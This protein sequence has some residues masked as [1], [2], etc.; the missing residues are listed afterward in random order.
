MYMYRSDTSDSL[1]PAQMPQMARP[2]WCV[3][4]WHIEQIPLPC[5]CPVFTPHLVLFLR[6]MSRTH[7]GLLP[8]ETLGLVLEKGTGRLT[9]Y[10]NG[11]RMGVMVRS[12][13]HCVRGIYI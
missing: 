11:V 8:G 1:P 5:F 3:S 13:A 9:A 7:T 2:D 6:C 12:H 10:R 4:S